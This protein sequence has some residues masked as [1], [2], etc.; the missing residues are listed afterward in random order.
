MLNNY[1]S[2]FTS[3]ANIAPGPWTHR[4]CRRGCSREIVDANN[5]VLARIP[6]YFNLPNGFNHDATIAVITTAPE[7]LA[8]LREAAYHLDVAGVPLKPEFYDLINR[9]SVTMQPITGP[10]HDPTNQ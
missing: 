8:A 5:R 2:I 3:T 6:V 10:R 7:L 9:A 1:M 4:W